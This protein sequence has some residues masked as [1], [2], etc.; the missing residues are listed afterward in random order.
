LQ[1]HTTLLERFR[2]DSSVTLQPLKHKARQKKFDVFLGI[3]K[4]I[5]RSDC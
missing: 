1:C 2:N 3:L 4:E 5:F